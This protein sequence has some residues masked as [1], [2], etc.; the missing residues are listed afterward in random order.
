MLHADP[1]HLPSHRQLGVTEAPQEHLV[2]AA[3]SFTAADPAGCQGSLDRLRGVVRAELEDQLA[4]ADSETGEL[5]YGPSHDDYRLS[6]TVGFSA[7]GYDRLAVPTDRRPADLR[8]IPADV[9]DATGAGRGAYLP[10]EGDVILKICSDDVFVAEHALRRVEHELAGDFTVVWAQ[11]GAQRY[12]SHASKPHRSDARA[13]I[14]FKDGTNNLDPSNPDDRALI[15]TDHT[16]TDYP[17]V[18]T[19]DQYQ[20]ARFPADLRPPPAGAEPAVLDDGTYMAVEVIVLDTRGWDA[21]PVAAQERSV[22]RTKVTGDMLA[23]PDPASHV[24]KAN[25]RRPGTDD[26]Q[27][28]ILRRGYPL[29]RPLDAVLA[30]GLAFIAFGRTLS[31]Q[32]EFIRRAWIN[33]PDFPT[34]GAGPDLLLF[35]FADKRLV[36]GGYYFV[37][38]LAHGTQ[39]WSWVV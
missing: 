33:N 13:L 26:L 7:S 17:P 34:V 31:A 24:L 37:P 27:R 32:A 10:G 2:L 28:R 35:G 5:G 8:P 20:G 14:G 12:G 30:R 15:F 23:P 25:P 29:L 18:P 22:G 16:R 9:V 36:C 1:H 21:Q 4:A 11:T 3:L 6:V 39:P 19:S 38:P